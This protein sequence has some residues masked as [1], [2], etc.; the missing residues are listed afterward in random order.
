MTPA[1]IGR[2]HPA[3][4]LRAEIARTVDGRGGLVLVTGEAGI[5]KTSLVTDAV[6]EARRQGALVLGGTCWDS[7]SAPG[8][9]PWV[10][11]VR[12]LRRAAGPAEW[13]AAEDAAG[14]GLAVLLGEGPDGEA[15][16]GFRLYDAVTSA[17]VA[18]A[19]HR[20]VV[21]VLD[22]LHWADTASLRLLEFAARHTWSERL[23][24]VGTYRDA[25]VEWAEHPLRPLLL[26]LVAKATAVTLTGLDRAGVGA[27]LARTAGREP[28]AGLVAEVH[29]RTGGNPFFVEQTARL[30]HGGGPVTAIAPGV[31]D[32]LRRRLAPLP[33]PAVRLLT[34]AAVLGREFPRRVLAAAAEIPAAEADR[35]LDRAV[36]ARL[37][38][39]RD[40]DR[41][42]FVHDLVRETLLET[43]DAAGAR[44]WHA[45]VVRAVG[46][47]ADLDGQVLPAEL[48]RHAH[49]AGPE[50]TP[51][52]AV[53]HLL[54]AARDAAHRM[55][56]EEAVVHYRRALEQPVSNPR[57]RVLT[58]LD[59]GG[60][61]S[62][63]AEPEAGRQAYDQAVDEARRSD[64]P[65]LLAMVALNLYRYGEHRGAGERR[66]E[67]L[68]EAYERLV[69]GAAEP[70]AT[71]SPDRLVQELSAHVAALVRHDD[72]DDA[73]MVG[74]W[75]RHDAIWGPG[76]AAERMSLI[77]ELIDVARRT[78]SSD[79]EI[80]A[81][82]FRW[83]TLLEQ[84]DP[85]Y[86][87]RFDEFVDLA[88]G[89]DPR[90]ALSALIDRCIIAT[91]AGRFGE[92]ESL[93]AEAA[94]DFR[95]GMAY[96]GFMAGHLHWAIL[97]AQGRFEEAL[98]VTERAAE[99]GHPVQA[100]LRGVTAAH[101][102]DAAVALHHLAEV[103]AAPPARMY[104]ALLLRFQA[105]A[106]ALSGDPERC[107]R[108][109]AALLPH[110]GQW[111]VSLF[112][113]EVSGPMDLWLGG[114]DAAQGRQDAAV[115]RFTT[116]YESAVRLRSLPW[117]AEAGSRLV[118]ALLARNAPGDAGTAA[119]LRA[120]V[121]RFAAETG[122]RHLAGREPAANVFRFDGSV[123]TLGFAGRTVHMP[124]A[125]GLRD[126]RV[127]L[128]APGTDVPAVRLA[129][130]A[131]GELVVAA[132]G[133]GG[134]DVLDEEARIR[135]KRRLARLD[136][137]IEQAVSRGDDG[138][139][140]EYDRERAALL[141]E[142]RAA[143]GLAGRDRRLGDEAERARKTVT[144]RIRDTLRKLDLRHP[145][146]AAHLR[147]S[148][149][150]GATC[151][152]RPGA[153]TAWWL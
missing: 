47:S 18:V 23:L 1:L 51:P 40:A 129:D 136:E 135:Y 2:E 21:V 68:G 9:W 33:A 64:H 104:A 111:A 48:A 24:L 82:S 73:L 14:G 63:L 42:A 86:L 29:R 144:A 59:L 140:A 145:E 106:A 153:E 36:A 133:M 118:E 67:L 66:T 54:A 3:G 35:L 79:M 19:Q 147:S 38:V 134:D 122:M 85:R 130:P 13:A 149:S 99:A 107:E 62:H 101:R 93:L 52:T 15:A 30:W 10:Q 43:L 115:E 27:L 17:L 25:E 45:A 49:L 100:L 70:G 53:G 74:L 75:A 127:L 119:D 46:G 109:R 41:F 137:E 97:L 7:E 26:P 146:L 142:L 76:T 55:A 81:A 6:G 80:F 50:L 98:V 72:D 102:G 61:L 5:G 58:L 123:W 96:F 108:A 39:A 112:G 125:K 89:E 132:R 110:A 94:D 8:Y 95:D 83:V 120:E 22:D 131:G 28:P 90:T 4:V 151:A 121:E 116:A 71:A 56:F 57:R 150:T 138:R 114:L 11:V 105:Q 92:A 141:D 60:A 32:T 69:R 91:V 148:V 77:D 84:G 113:C 103:E 124:D 44:R 34:G 12:G 78:G 20:P 117:A 139:A 87:D 152:Y 31:R 37:V 65:E 128:G 16:E 88:G 126:L 143:T